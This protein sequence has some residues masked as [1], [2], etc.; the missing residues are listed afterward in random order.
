MYDLNVDFYNEPTEFD[1][2]M[3]QFKSELMSAVKSEYIDE[4]NR[5]KQENESLQSIK[6]NYDEIRLDFENRKRELE[7]EY[8]QKRASVKRD[9]LSELMKDVSGEYYTV[10][11]RN[12]LGPKCD[13]CDKYRKVHYKTPLGKD[14]SETCDCAVRI[15]TYQPHPI[16]LHSFSIRS[17]EGTAW[18]EVKENFGDEWLSYYESTISGS[19]LIK[20][21]KDFERINYSYRSLFET[22]E[23]AQKYC[24]IK[25]S[26]E[27]E[28]AVT[29]GKAVAKF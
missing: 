25:N 2:A 14:S 16:L 4:M 18:Y 28:V 3:H 13:K 21:E 7:Y 29:T 5:L 26:E 11:S 10:A 9:R 22:K 20:N 27:K 15:Y 6:K 8:Q 17:G 12:I 24:D 23:L 19:E 1:M